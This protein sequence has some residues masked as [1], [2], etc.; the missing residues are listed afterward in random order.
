MKHAAFAAA[1][2]LTGAQAAQAHF[3]IPGASGFSGGLLH[4]LFVL[5]HALALVALGLLLAAQPV[6]I[7]LWLIAAFVLAMLLSF[8]LVSLAFATNSGELAALILAAMTG[9]LLAS[10]W[11]IPGTAAALLSAGLGAA[12]LFDSVPAVPTVRETIISLCGTALS[13]TALIAVTAFASAALPALWQ[14]IGIRIAGSWIAASA[15]LVL[16]LRLAKL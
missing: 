16:A 10:G 9:L 3:V 4:P 11:K 15:V 12:I 13:A 5:S 6:R 8:E 14:R 2:L 1:L 7:R